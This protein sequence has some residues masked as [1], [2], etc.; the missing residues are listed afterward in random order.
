M[1][2]YAIIEPDNK[3]LECRRL[4]MQS[5]ENALK[6]GDEVFNKLA[7]KENENIPNTITFAKFKESIKNIDHE[8]LKK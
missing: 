3:E 2:S 1:C 5:I 4:I 8:N 7:S 6:K